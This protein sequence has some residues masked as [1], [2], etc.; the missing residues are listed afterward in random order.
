MPEILEQAGSRD[1]QKMWEAV[2][3]LD[4]QNAMGTRATAQQ[5]MA[6]DE[7][8]RFTKKYQNLLIIQWHSGI[9]RTVYPPDL[10]LG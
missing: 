4:I 3:K 6:F 5:G 1:H 8:G 9:P 7:K 10:A 2:R